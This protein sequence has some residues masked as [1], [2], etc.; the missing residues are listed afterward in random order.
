MRKDFIIATQKAD[1]YFMGTHHYFKESINDDLESFFKDLQNGQEPRNWVPTYF[2]PKLNN[3]EVKLAQSN[4]QDFCETFMFYGSNATEV[5][6]KL[7]KSNLFVRGRCCR[8]TGT[9]EN[10]PFVLTKEYQTEPPV[11]KSRKEQNF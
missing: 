7:S 9:I 8:E 1:A 5:E 10:S 4:D 11:K 3:K 2:L 6:M